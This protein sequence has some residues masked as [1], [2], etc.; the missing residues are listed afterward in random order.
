[1]VRDAVPLGECGRALVVKLRHHGDVLLSSPVLSLL[2]ARAPQLEIDALV[3]DDTMPMLEGHPALSRLYFVGRKWRER[4]AVQ[5]FFL[6]KHL[7]DSLRARKYELLVHLSEQPRG[8]WLARLLGTRWSVA[9][10]M[11]GRGKF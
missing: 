8:A 10:S 11:P 7:L 3:Y 9:P 2:K 1:M 4:S 6:E 5:R